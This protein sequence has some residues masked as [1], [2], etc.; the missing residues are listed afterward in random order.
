M[1]EKWKSIV[2]N[3][4]K[5]FWASLTDLPKAFDCLLHESFALPFA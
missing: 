4:K 3:K 5:T 1:L 2:D